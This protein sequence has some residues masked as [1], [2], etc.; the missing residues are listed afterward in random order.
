MELVDA[1]LFAQAFKI[2]A[3][4][5]E[6]WGYITTSS[7]DRAN[8]RCDY[9]A[10][11]PLIQRWSNEAL[12]ASKATGQ[13]SYG[14]VRTMHPK[15]LTIAGV[16]AGKLIALKFDDANQ[17]VLAGAHITDDADW[18]KCENGTYTGFSIGGHY[19]LPKI[20]EPDGAW[21]VVINPTEVSL[22]DRPC[23]PECRFTAVKADGLEEMR[24][25][26]STDP[27]VPMPEIAADRFRAADRFV[28]LVPT[29]HA[30]LVKLGL[31]TD[32]AAKVSAAV[33]DSGRGSDA[34][35]DEMTQEEMQAQIDAAASALAAA[36]ER[37][38]KAEADLTAAKAAA[39]ATVQEPAKVE[40]PVVFSDAQKA[41]LAQIIKGAL[42]DL[43]KPTGVAVADHAAKVAVATK[44]DDAPKEGLEAFKAVL[45]KPRHL[46]DVIEGNK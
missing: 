20:K 25:F 24:A 14:N 41:E 2:D 6:V 35:G 38:T 8:E 15:N 32:Q 22:V 45:S 13:E 28:D 18:R 11:K 23:N 31:L 26:A 10:M 40:P 36:E 37:A 29:I 4:K 21:K 5:R 19:V 39:A 7:V 30:E 16:A 44:E 42:A 3:T 17:R 27:N 34:T 9:W 12:Q 1:S 43:P 33:Q 46:S